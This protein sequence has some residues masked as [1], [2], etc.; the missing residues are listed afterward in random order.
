M[1]NQTNL[2]LGLT[3]FFEFSIQG[4]RI[5]DLRTKAAQDKIV[6]ENKT[7]EVR[8]LP[9]SEVAHAIFAKIT[10]Q[11]ENVERKILF[12]AKKEGHPL[13]KKYI[14]QGTELTIIL[15]NRM[16]VQGNFKEDRFDGLVT[17][18]FYEMTKLRGVVLPDGVTPE[19]NVGCQFKGQGKELYARSINEAFKDSIIKAMNEAQNIQQ[20]LTA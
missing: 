12:F 7:V 11:N 6:K 20:H 13:Y 18:T 17:V 5:E 3:T 9:N 14:I 10:T 15:S 19:C 8:E 16:R 1:N 2:L 4:E